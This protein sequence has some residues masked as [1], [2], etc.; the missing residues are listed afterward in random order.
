M[1][2]INYK[3][4]DYNKLEKSANQGTQSLVLIDNDKCI[5]LFK[6]LYDYQKRDMY[7]K[8]MYLDGMHI[9]GIIMPEELIV[10]G[11]LLEGF[12]M[13]YFKNS[14]TIFKRFSS[15]RLLD[16]KEFFDVVLKCC[17]I[18]KKAHQEGIIFQDLSFSNILID[19]DDKV[20]FNDIDS[21]TYQGIS[22]H[23]IS[24]IL[25][26]Y[27][28][29]AGYEDINFTKET[30]LLSFFLSFYHLLYY[31]EIQDLSKKEYY[32]LFNKLQTIRN[33]HNVFS[34]VKRTA[35]V[36]IPYLDELISLED[37]YVIDRMTQKNYRKRIKK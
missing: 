16:T 25:N 19:K 20:M 14:E 8:F 18:I 4:I 31:K 12:T 3:D 30:D 34:R 27:L 35:G 24:N 37:D 26:H 21:C 17:D 7:R 29:Y 33:G 23:Y 13:P 9:D 36:R 10:N 32:Q 6:F 28:D 1:E 11:E 15:N 22:S 5:K 2:K